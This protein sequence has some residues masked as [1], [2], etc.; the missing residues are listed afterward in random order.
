MDKLQIDK[1]AIILDTFAYFFVTIDLYGSKRLLALEER[2]KNY[3]IPSKETSIHKRTANY[4]VKFIGLLLGLLFAIIFIDILNFKI[5]F[6]TWVIVTIV[7]SIFFAF[8]EDYLLKLS[9]K[10]VMK[11]FQVVIRILDKTRFE[12]FL[13]ILRSIL[14]VISKILTYRNIGH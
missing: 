14:F 6:R 10:F 4:I 7:G 12:G 9:L 3:F 1:L 5:S 2:I 13:V 11:V 8:I